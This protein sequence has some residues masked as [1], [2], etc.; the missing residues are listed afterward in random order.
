MRHKPNVQKKICITKRRGGIS[1]NANNFTTQ[2]NLNMPKIGL[3]TIF[4]LVGWNITY[5]CPHEILS[6][7]IK[8]AD[9]R[10]IC[11]SH[12]RWWADR[13]WNERAGSVLSALFLETTCGV[14]RGPCLMRKT[15]KSQKHPL[16][17]A[18]QG[19]VDWIL[20]YE[21]VLLS[22]AHN[23]TLSARGA[24]KHTHTHTKESN[25]ALGEFERVLFLY[26]P[27]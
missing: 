9:K 18:L 16:L 11:T 19:H 22:D 20:W 15:W 8:Q 13:W 2:I 3:S 26:K 7:P 1:R 12:L 25:W 21:K 27:S 23:K 6:L 14:S 24:F 17:A 10:V 4:E 5:A